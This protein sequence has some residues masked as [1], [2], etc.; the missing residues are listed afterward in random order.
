[1]PVTQSTF[2]VSTDWLEDH[3][4][5]PGL[6]IFDCTGIAGKDVRNSG[7]EEHYDR[8]HVPGAAYLDMADPKGIMTDPSGNFPYTWPTQEQFEAAMA[9]LGVGN[10]DRVIL[11]SGA[12]SLVPGSGLTWATRAWWLMHH[13][14]VDCAILDGGWQ[15]WVAEG[16]PVSTE[17]KV[18]SPG[19]FHAR[20]DWKRGVACKHDVRSA[21][22]EQ[23]ALVIDT[24]T[25]QSY[26]GEPSRGYGA[27][28]PRKGH[29]T[30][31]V[32]VPYESL[33]DPDTGCFL[34]P[35]EI[36]ARF[37]S[38]GLAPQDHAITYCGAGVGATV[39]GFALKLA[40]HQHVAIYDGSL[41]E[42]SRDPAMPMTDPSST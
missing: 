4:G 3:L 6:R 31:A 29:I 36:L 16:R 35:D 12:N 20:P 22:D 8:H 1:M 30:G 38:Q 14:G 7:R 2:L 10:S 32:N 33:T 18:Y 17:P 13:F 42:W 19:S 28:G 11:Y 40:G 34:G 5:D 25:P 24:L 9:E 15:K 39:A 37:S 27:F 41:I 23:G 21:L 26:R